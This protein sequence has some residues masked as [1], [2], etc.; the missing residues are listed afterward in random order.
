VL[1]G[2][3]LNILTYS[4]M[5]NAQDD[6]ILV[7]GTLEMLPDS[8]NG[9]TSATSISVRVRLNLGLAVLKAR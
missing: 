2:N 6:I 9:W 4:L 8:A 5:P 1:P 7:T 3:I